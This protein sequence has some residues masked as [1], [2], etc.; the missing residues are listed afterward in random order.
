MALGLSDKNP[1]KPMTNKSTV[2]RYMATL[3]SQITASSG[4]APK[5]S[6]EPAMYGA[7]F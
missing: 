6:Q 7:R 2:E 4:A 1:V 5:V 3:R